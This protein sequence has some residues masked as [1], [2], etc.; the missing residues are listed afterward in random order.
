MMVNGGQ[1]SNVMNLTKKTIDRYLRNSVLVTQFKPLKAIPVHPT[2]NTL[3]RPLKGN[4]NSNKN[5]GSNSNYKSNSKNINERSASLGLVRWA[6]DVGR[7]GVN[8]SSASRGTDY[9]Y[10]PVSGSTKGPS[11]TTSNSKYKA[12]SDNTPSK[13][14]GTSPQEKGKGKKGKDKDRDKVVTRDFRPEEGITDLRKKQPFE[15]SLVENPNLDH[16]PRL[17]HG[18]DR[19]L[20]SPGVHR[21][22]D[23]HTRQFNFGK[24]LN[25]ILQPDEVP[26]YIFNNFTPPSNDDKL[27]EL[28]KHYRKKFVVSTSSTSGPLSQIYYSVFGTHINV[29]NVSTEFKDEPRQ[30]TILSRA[31]N[32]SKITN[33]GTVHSVNAWNPDEKAHILSALGLITEQMLTK[34][35]LEIRNILIDKS[36]V[37]PVD[38]PQCF[39]YATAGCMLLRSQLDCHHPTLPNKVFDLKTR[40]T[41]CVRMDVDGY[42]NHLEY[43]LTSLKGLY[44]S[45]E[46][47]Y[48]DLIRAGFLK[49]SF[50]VRIGK[51]DGVLVCYH[52]TKELFGFQYVPLQEMESFLYATPGHATPGFSLLLMIYNDILET[53]HAKFGNEKTFIV[54]Y[55]HRPQALDISVMVPPEDN[56]TMDPHHPKNKFYE[57][58]LDFYFVNE[59]GQLYK[60]LNDCRTGENVSVRI[61]WTE[62]TPS[63]DMVDAFKPKQAKPVDPRY[64]E[65]VKQKAKKRFL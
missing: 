49:Y 62:V 31:R 33:H 32:M 6:M 2:S 59:Q 13:Y 12:G 7:V 15:F 17:R 51:M 9:F 24:V 63:G 38:E 41:L 54:S 10:P 34:T 60:T 55:L 39:R 58:H 30:F 44:G 61:K 40:A 50:Q 8:L 36:S 53:L 46:R 52:N 14:G 37:A 21:L 64:L 1:N 3:K 43:R 48:F 56:L 45:Y 25:S 42:Q 16:V 22:R 26:S 4:N 18:L 47:E 29:P 11:S 23:P 57:F 5:S 28:A 65:F 20:F 27:K 35:E 19:V